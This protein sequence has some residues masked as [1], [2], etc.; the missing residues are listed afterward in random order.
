MQRFIKA[1]EKINYWSIILLPFSV[2]I[3]P[4]VANTVIAIMIGTFLIEKLIKKE[5]LCS[6]SLP[7]AIFAVF[8]VIGMFTF[9]N[10][11]SI[12]NSLSGMIKLFKFLMIFLA[13]SENIKDRQD[14]KRIAI[15][16]ACAIS[17]I[18][19]DA[20]WQLF[21]GK[22]FIRG[23]PL[24]GNIGLARATASFP[25]CNALGVYL[26]GLTAL[27]AGLALFSS[28]LKNRIFFLFLR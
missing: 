21:S 15:S 25:G 9:I 11:V 24:N 20:I 3:A 18:G 2:G 26:T 1:I 28:G 22:D 19:I 7:V 27:T 13:C 23:N 8:M 17:L 12:K 16:V 10:T 14:F 4:G 5:K 6:V